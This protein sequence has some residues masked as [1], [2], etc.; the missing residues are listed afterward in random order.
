[1]MCVS[2]CFNLK[3]KKEMHLNRRM[4]ES[5]IK[6]PGLFKRHSESLLGL[7]L[8]DVGGGGSGREGIT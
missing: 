4:M 7:C 5:K 6:I 3:K 8:G 2:H 1:M